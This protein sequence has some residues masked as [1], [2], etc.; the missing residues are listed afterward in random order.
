M[1]Q[2]VAQQRVLV[3]IV[4]LVPMIMAFLNSDMFLHCFN[5]S[6]GPRTLHTLHSA[7]IAAGRKDPPVRRKGQRLDR[8]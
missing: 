6:F 2:F 3:G 1:V 8:R 5:R 7:I 4:T